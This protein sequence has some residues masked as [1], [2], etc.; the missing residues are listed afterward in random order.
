VLTDDVEF[1]SHDVS[2][3]LHL[4]VKGAEALFAG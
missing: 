4:S 3:K 2:A 1:T